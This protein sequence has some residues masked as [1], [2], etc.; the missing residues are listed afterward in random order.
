MLEL[1]VVD[2]LEGLFLPV[3]EVV[4]V[5]VIGGDG[6]SIGLRL[7]GVGVGVRMGVGVGGGGGGGVFGS[8]DLVEDGEGVIGWDKPAPEDEGEPK[9][10]VLFWKVQ[11]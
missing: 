6:F 3:E 2:G 7:L 4:V 8:E 11:V 9:H 5:L 10:A 1:D